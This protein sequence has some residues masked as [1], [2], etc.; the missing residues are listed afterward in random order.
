MGASFIHCQY[1][2]TNKLNKR[3]Q[4]IF[5]H[6][7]LDLLS[8]NN[9]CG[10][11]YIPVQNIIFL[12]IYNSQATKVRKN[13]VYYISSQRIKAFIIR[14]SRKWGISTH[15]NLSTSHDQQWSSWSRYL[16][17]KVDSLFRWP[18]DFMAAR[19]TKHVDSLITRNNLFHEVHCTVPAVIKLY[20]NR[21]LGIGKWLYLRWFW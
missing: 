14:K 8:Y 2:S 20:L 16:S 21:G 10:Y 9:Y 13:Q 12:V 18:S 15:N 17:S 19:C 5:R 3:T 1:F 7:F 6:Y 11:S 4:G